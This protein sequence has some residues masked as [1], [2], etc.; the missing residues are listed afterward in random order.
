MESLRTPD[1]LFEDLPDFPWQPNYVS[2][3]KGLEGL[4]VHYVDEGSTGEVDQPVFLC[5]HG[6]P[7]WCY[8]YRHM[9]P[10]FLAA[11]GRVIA[12]DFLGFGRS[13]KPVEDSEYSFHFHRNM[14]L[15]FVAQL[16]LKNIT[17]V[18]QDWGGVL[19]LTLPMDMPARIKRLIIMN[20]ALATGVAPSQGFL[21]WRAYSAANPDLKIGKLMKQ[22]CPHLSD[23]EAAAY[24]APW[25][26]QSFKAG[27]RQF[28]KLVM[29]E[30]D[31]EGV[32]TSL[33][34]AAFWKDHWQGQSFM[35]IGVN[36]PVL[37]VD[38]MM[39]MHGLI[40]NCP[41]PL[42]VNDGGHFVQEWGAKVAR[43][44]LAEFSR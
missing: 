34:A 41:E 17:L 7:T 35:A 24:D 39:R 9:I 3:L 18:V 4:R 31:M 37:G 14:L 8:L 44:A 33:R 16:D 36:D 30:P 29:T 25:P 2:D 5:L 38:I 11:G 43:A 1:E 32:Q 6:Q 21:D 40:R 42:M 26:D 27:V 22:S 19:G 20:T 12:P 10:E 15:A 13:D 23:G 28:P